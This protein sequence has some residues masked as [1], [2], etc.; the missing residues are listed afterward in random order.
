MVS[1]SALR[2]SDHAG[3]TPAGRAGCNAALHRGRPPRGHQWRALGLGPVAARVCG[4]WRLA[5]DPPTGPAG[6]NA[7]LH[8]VLPPALRAPRHPRFR[9]GR[10]VGQIGACDHA[11]L[12]AD[13]RPSGRRAARAVAVHIGPHSCCRAPGGEGDREPADRSDRTARWARQRVPRMARERWAPIRAGP[14]PAPR[15]RPAVTPRYI[16]RTVHSGAARLPSRPS[17]PVAM[18][19]S[20][21][22]CPSRDWMRSM[23]RRGAR[24]TVC[25]RGSGAG[26]LPNGRCADQYGGAE[27]AVRRRCAALP[28]L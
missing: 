12:L 1:P 8:P 16:H 26:L 2:I 19:V 20:S 10:G 27:G 24:E 15:G 28:P 13:T 18:T 22:N 4:S 25:Y 23:P 21:S 17:T 3:T 5:R 7:A 9:E 11:S 6:C 14:R